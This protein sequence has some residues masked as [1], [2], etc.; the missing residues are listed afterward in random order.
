ML[1]GF[2]KTKMIENINTP[3]LLTNSPQDI[4]NIIYKNR[5]QSKIIYPFPWKYILMIIR[6]LP[7]I[8]FKRL[9][10]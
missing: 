6:L 2:V 3:V 7:Q 5:F 8:I 10:L 1:P 9:K 4:S